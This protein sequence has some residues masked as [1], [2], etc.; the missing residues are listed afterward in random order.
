[1]VS[2]LQF[3]MPGVKGVQFQQT[4]ADMEVLHLCGLNEKVATND[5]WSF[6]LEDLVVFSAGVHCW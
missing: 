2:Q 4:P 1:M 3:L 5:T 6:R